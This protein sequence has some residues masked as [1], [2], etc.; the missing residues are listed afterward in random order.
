MPG[1]LDQS[2]SDIDPNKNY[3]EELVGDGKK[4][5]DNEALAKSKYMADMHISLLEKRYDQLREDFKKKDDEAQ[6]TAQLSD[7]I[8]TYEEKLKQPV[9]SEQ[10]R[11]ER[12][13]EKPAVDLNELD[14]LMSEKL[15]QGLSA[16]EVANRQKENTRL[17]VEKLKER[18]GDN[19]QPVVKQQVQSLGMTDEMFNQMV[20]DAPAALLKTLGVGD[21]GERF[22]AP[23]QSSG[24]FQFKG[25]A[26]RTWSYYQEMKQKNPRLYHDPKTLIQME[27]DAL[28]LGEVFG[29]GDFDR[30]WRR[31]PPR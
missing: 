12:G 20:K 14:K 16:Y 8:K 13:P 18:F 30:E 1:I 2:E 17:V 10:P 29:D 11:S 7:L 6:A 23:A 3:Y 15:Q 5:K 4:F 9:S 28:A 31:N 19:Y 22:Q 24:S 26:K 27:K 25:P 21:A